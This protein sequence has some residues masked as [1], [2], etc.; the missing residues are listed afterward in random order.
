M[1]SKCKL[2][3]FII[4]TIFLTAPAL[5]SDCPSG[6]K[7]VRDDITETSDTIYVEPICHRLSNTD[8]ETLAKLEQRIAATRTAMKNLQVRSGRLQADI[9]EWVKLAEEARVKARL[10][11]LDMAADLGLHYLRDHLTTAELLAKRQDNKLLGVLPRFNG[12]PLQKLRAETVSK[13]QT[14]QSNKEFVNILEGIRTTSDVTAALGAI[15]VEPKDL[16][17]WADGVIE[18]MQIFVKHPTLVLVLA[19]SKLAEA[20]LYGWATAFIAKGNYKELAQIGEAQY[21]EAKTLT[22]MYIE[23]LKQRDPLLGKRPLQ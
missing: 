15:Y 17:K 19:D 6:T 1:Q 10:A 22:K 20:T 16:E 8:K 9:D 14:V 4:I 11:I 21:Q 23:D 12:T 18:L 3:L 13:L 2:V 5:A 7:W